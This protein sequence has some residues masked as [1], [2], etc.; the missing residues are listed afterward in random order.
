MAQ[1]IVTKKTLLFEALTTA[2]K[3]ATNTTD[4]AVPY[5]TPLVSPTCYKVFMSISFFAKIVP[6]VAPTTSPR[7]LWYPLQFPLDKEGN[8]DR[9]LCPRAAM[10]PL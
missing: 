9:G 2:T 8:A 1:N 5:L 7:P 10:I 4:R 3:E 6:F